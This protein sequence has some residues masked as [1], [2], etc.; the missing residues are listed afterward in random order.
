MEVSAPLQ[1]LLSAVYGIETSLEEAD[2]GHTNHVFLRLPDGRILDATADQ[3][4]LP[5][6]YLGPLPE[7]YREARAP[8][9]PALALLAENDALKEENER[10][11]SEVER[12]RASTYGSN[13]G[14]PSDQ[15]VIKCVRGLHA[16]PARLEDERAWCCSFLGCGHVRSGRTPYCKMHRM[17]AERHGDPSVILKPGRKKKAR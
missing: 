2:L 11:R 17:R 13:P 15:V 12:L 10:L 5:C 4:D 1:G 8:V 16:L 14:V 6:V 7:L 3:F 9:L